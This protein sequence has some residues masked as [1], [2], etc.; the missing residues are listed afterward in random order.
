[1]P[2]DRAQGTMLKQRVPVVQSPFSPSW[3]H[4]S[5]ISWDRDL[6]HLDE[7]TPSQ[8]TPSSSPPPHMITFLELQHEPVFD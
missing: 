8:I 5:P 6:C 1:M 2:V 4:C 7:M 3:L